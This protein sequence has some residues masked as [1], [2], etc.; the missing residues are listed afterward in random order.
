[1]LIA[2]FKRLIKQILKF[3][4]PVKLWTR[5]RQIYVN[6]KKRQIFSLIPRLKPLEIKNSPQYIVSLTSCGNRL[7]DTAPFAIIT[8][9]NQRVKP[10][11]IILWVAN[12]DK[13]NI[14]Q[15][16]EK[17]TEK[18]LE[19]RF[20]ED[21][22]AHKKLIPALEN[23]PEDYIV[24][25]DDNVYYTKT[26]FELLMAEHKKNPKKII[27]HRAHGI[28]VDENH[29]LLP[30][31]QWGFDIEPSMVYEHTFVS[32]GGYHT[33]ESVFPA[34]AGG[35]LYP[36]KCFC[37]DV[38]NKELFMNLAPHTTDIWFWAM[39]VINKEYFGEEPPYIVVENK[40]SWNLQN[41]EPEQIPSENDRQIKAVIEQYPQ[42]KE[43]L[44]KIG[45]IIVKTNMQV[46][47]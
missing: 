44:K 23:F 42:I 22:K 9:L 15:G 32:Q 6:H 17:L 2:E 5:L 34:G 11:R 37:K 7:T 33:S 16:M 28:R 26:W 45:K 46:R 27:C 31:T 43:V 41:I 8:L 19:I 3:F 13:T 24:I 30:Y 18:G 12:E 20:C 36:P 1:M 10:D 25:A 40:S 39:T 29:N 38:A 47:R 21:I 35:I 14:P 4:L